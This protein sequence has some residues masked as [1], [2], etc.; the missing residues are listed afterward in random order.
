MAPWHCARH[1]VL[2]TCTLSLWILTVGPLTYLSLPLLMGSFLEFLGGWE[3]PL[4]SG[5]PGMGLWGP[6]HSHCF[7]LSTGPHHCLLH[8]TFTTSSLCSCTLDAYLGPSLTLHCLGFHLYYTHASLFSLSHSHTLD[9]HWGTPHHHSTASCLLC[10]LLNLDFH[11][12]EGVLH[13]PAWSLVS[14]SLRSGWVEVSFAHTYHHLLTFC[15][16]P[17][18]L[19]CLT[20]PATS[21]TWSC[22]GSH[23]LQVYWEEVLVL[24]NFC[25]SAL[26]SACTCYCRCWV[27]ITWNTCATCSG[28]ISIS[29]SH[30]LTLALTSPL[31]LLSATLSGC[32]SFLLTPAFHCTPPGTTWSSLPGSCPA[33]ACCTTGPATLWEVSLPG[34]AWMGMLLLHVGPGS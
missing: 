23:H 14:L 21:C 13:I 6:A 11:C 30:T 9:F 12:M 25:S 15:L 18:C 17:G 1:K 28:R 31:T 16:L 32:H 4:G 3:V 22:T 8:L 5:P 2:L 29:R 24:W 20:M 19:P 33:T 26:H 10:F 7:F 34:S 27:E